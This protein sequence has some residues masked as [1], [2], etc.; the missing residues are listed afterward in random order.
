MDTLERGANQHSANALPSQDDAA[1]PRLRAIAEQLHR[2]AP[3]RTNPHAYFEQK[4]SM[5]A[6]LRRLALGLDQVVPRRPKAIGTDRFSVRLR[7]NCGTAEMPK[8][9]LLLTVSKMDAASCRH[10]LRRRAQQTRRHRLRLR[11]LDLFQWAE[12]RE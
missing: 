12:R 8:P 11:G 3:S 6:E 5:V 1:G 2:L 4:S 10:C 7:Q 9:G